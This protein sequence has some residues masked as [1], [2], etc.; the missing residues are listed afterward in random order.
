MQYLLFFF[1][2]QHWLRE[3][4]SILPLHCIACRNLWHKTVVRGPGAR[5]ENFKP[6]RGHRNHW[7]VG[8]VESRASLITTEGKY[9]YIY[10]DLLEIEP[11]LSSPS[12]RT[13][14]TVL[15]DLTNH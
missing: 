11:G 13:L 6:H 4:T 5:P 9:I 1:S 3:R 2:R 8:A 7:A 15:T 12:V 10:A 14:A